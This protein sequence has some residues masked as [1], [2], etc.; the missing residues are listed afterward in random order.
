MCFIQSHYFSINLKENI[1]SIDIKNDYFD[2]EF[3]YRITFKL[4]KK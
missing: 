3:L 2:F 1:S 4:I